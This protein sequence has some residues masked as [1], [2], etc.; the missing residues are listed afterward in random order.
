MKGGMWCPIAFDSLDYIDCDKIASHL[1]CV[2]DGDD[3]GYEF[4][5]KKC[6]YTSD[7]YTYADHKGVE[8]EALNSWFGEGI[9]EVYVNKKAFVNADN[10][11][12][13]S[14]NR[15]KANVGLNYA[16]ADYMAEPVE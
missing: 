5:I 14:H 9:Y 2:T 15:I 7:I 12:L 3:I 13:G 4:P 11:A 8:Y 10:G 1:A 6:I 16:L